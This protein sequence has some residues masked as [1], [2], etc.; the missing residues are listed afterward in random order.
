M[1]ELTHEQKQFIDDNFYEGL[2]EHELDKQK[3]DKLS[4]PYEL[5]YLVNRHN[6][7]D[8]IMLMQWVAESKICSEAT[9]LQLFWLTQPQ[10]FQHYKLTDELK[11]DYQDDEN[12]IFTLLK[13]IYHNFPRGFYSKADIP[14]DPADYIIKEPEVPGFMKKATNGEEPYVYYE[15]KEVNSWFGEY[16]QTRIARCDTAIEL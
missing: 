16:L 6:W 4:T 10:D 14:F 9:V 12:E 1:K 8:G 11:G 2:D 3:F 7:N 15:E 13:T 5:H